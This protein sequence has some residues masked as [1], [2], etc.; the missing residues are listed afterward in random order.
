[1]KSWL[2]KSK[3]SKMQMYLTHNLGKSIVAER[4]FRIIESKIYKYM[5]SI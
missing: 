1:M 2:E 3:K 5:T 4:F